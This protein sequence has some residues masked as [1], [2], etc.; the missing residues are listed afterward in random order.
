[1]KTVPV[2]LL[3]LVMAASALDL[4]ISAYTGL[5]YPTGK[6]GEGLNDGLDAG[7]AVSWKVDDFFRAG[8]GLS[9]G[10]FGSSDMG[11]ASFTTVRPHL[12]VGY[13]LRPWG[14]VFNPGLTGSLGI[15]R[16]SLT[17]G[18]GADPVTWDFFWSAGLRWNFGLGGG[19][20]G[21][22]GPDFSSIVAEMRNGDSFTLLFGVSREVAI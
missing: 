6:W 15:C 20:R 7:M 4:D 12:K 13:Y 22:V 9:A 3:F 17:N 1:L 16:S 8:L 18:G 11:A 2:T 19:F 21:E 10:V 5:S 14:N